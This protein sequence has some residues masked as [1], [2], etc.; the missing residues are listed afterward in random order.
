MD[1]RGR[2][3]LILVAAF[4]CTF[5][6]MAGYVLGLRLPRRDPLIDKVAEA[7][8]TIRRHYL[9]EV[10]A[11]KLEQSTLEGMMQALDRY[12]EY[13]PAEEWEQTYS[14]NIMGE[15]AG[16]GIQVQKD[17]NGFLQILTPLEGSPAIEADIFPG[18]YVLEVDGETIRGWPMDRIV[19]KIRGEEGSVV[20]MKILRGEQEHD[21]VITRARITINPVRSKFVDEQAR[22]G[23]IRISEFSAALSGKNRFRSAAET[24]LAQGARALVVD[25]RFNGGGLLSEAVTLCDEFL[26]SGTIVRIDGRDPR[27]N[28]TFQAK[29][30]EPLESIPLVVLINEGTVSASEIFAGCIQDHK[31]GTLV[32][33]STYGK[34]LVQRPFSLQDGSRLKLTIARY[35]TPAGKFFDRDRGE[36][37]RPDVEVKLTREEY[38]T[39]VRAWHQEA[40]LKAMSG[41]K[42]QA[43]D[44]QLDKALE[45]LR[46]Q[47]N[48]Q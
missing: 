23:Y 19:R 11:E 48:G 6:L 30:G 16:V 46:A 8:Q 33:E 47:I 28:E 26:P 35:L 13:I 43:V 21:V 14:P 45:I 12:S 7:R 32:G 15:F 9:G 2:T 31:R 24:L 20:R 10:D 36:T 38:N 27:D 40:V 3:T 39:L 25:M 34:G 41:D 1:P 29:A 4:S 42:P 18:D 37:I 5:G 17:E 22:I 44:K